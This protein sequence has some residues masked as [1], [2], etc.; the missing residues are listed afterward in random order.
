MDMFEKSIEK[1]V[2]I[3]M[4]SKN[5]LLIGIIVISMTIF[6]ACSSD[7]P[8]VSINADTSMKNNSSDEISTDNEEI[9]TIESEK[10]VV[11]SLSSGEE[12]IDYLRKE[13]NMENNEDIEFD[14]HGGNLE[15]DDYG[16]YYTITLFSKS[17]KESGGSGTLERYRVYHDGKYELD[18]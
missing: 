15:K 6:T 2:L 13:L 12:A 17:W 4:G 8:Q 14:D 9:S 5:S 1:G 11:L 7:S 10:G 18:Y 16:S 3:E